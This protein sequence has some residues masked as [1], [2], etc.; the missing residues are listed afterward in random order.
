MFLKNPGAYHV[1]HSLRFLT[2]KKI[3]SEKQFGFQPAHQENMQSCNF[4]IEL[5]LIR[6]AL[7]ELF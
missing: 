6:I 1:Y 5:L 2:R 4:L 7:I 3:L